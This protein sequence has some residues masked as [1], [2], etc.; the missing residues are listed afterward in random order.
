MS[1]YANF[2][3]GAPNI[4]IPH[5]EIVDNAIIVWF[6][7]APSDETSRKLLRSLQDAEA[8]IYE[9][10]EAEQTNQYLILF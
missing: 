2:N 6:G 7:V 5:L 8:G 9:R 3:A 4:I 10:A 1:W